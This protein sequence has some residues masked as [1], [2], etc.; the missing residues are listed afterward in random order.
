MAALKDKKKD[1]LIGLTKGTDLIK[2]LVDKNLYSFLN[3]KSAAKIW[4][5]LKIRFQH[6]SPMNITRIFYKVGSIKLS[7]CKDVINYIGCYQMAF[8][9]IESLITK[10]L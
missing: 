2:K 1:Y 3:N 4:T 7:D 8:D 6:I 5:F 9:K 10:D